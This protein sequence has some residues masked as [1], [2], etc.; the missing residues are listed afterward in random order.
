MTDEQ[1]GAWSQMRRVAAPLRF[2]VIA[3]AEG[4][5][6][7]RGKFGDIE[8]YHAEGTH[9]AAYTAGRQDRLGRLLPR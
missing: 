4:Y 7:I 6:V 8:W 9:L 5:P 2:K 1:V 3:D